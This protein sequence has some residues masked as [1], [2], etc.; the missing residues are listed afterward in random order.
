MKVDGPKGPK[1]LKVL[2]FDSGV[3]A[4]G[5][6]IAQGAMSIYAATGGRLAVLAPLWWLAPQPFSTGKRLTR[7]SGR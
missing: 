3:A 1:V 5:G 4:E 6:G 2:R 7:F